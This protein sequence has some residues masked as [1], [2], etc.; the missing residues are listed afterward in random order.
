MAHNNYHAIGI[1]ESWCN[2][3]ISDGEL[4]LK[5][6]NLFRGD[7]K[8]GTGGGILL[9]LHK[10]LPPASLCI[11]LMSFDTDD[12]LWCTVTYVETINNFSLVLCTVPH[13]QVTLDYCP[14]LGVL[15][16]LDN[17]LNFF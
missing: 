13:L 11:S 9:Y 4:C 6:Y 8:S 2:E 17:F 14:L 7:R 12:S 3:S 16:S 1:A 10:S 15:M 5:G